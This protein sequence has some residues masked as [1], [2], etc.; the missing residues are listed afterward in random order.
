M[1]KREIMVGTCHIGIAIIFSESVSCFVSAEKSFWALSLESFMCMILA[2]A[3]WTQKANNGPPLL[4]VRGPSDRS[5]GF[6]RGKHASS[7]FAVLFRA[8]LLQMTL[9]NFLKTLKTVKKSYPSG[10]SSKPYQPLPDFISQ[11]LTTS[12]PLDASTISDLN[13]TTFHDILTNPDLK[14]SKCFRF[15]NLVIKNQS[16]VSFKPDLQAHLTLTC[17]LLKARLFSDAEAML[18]SVSVD[19]SLRYPFLVIASAVENCCFESK[20]ITKFYNLMLKVY[21]DNGKFGEVLKTFDYMKN[22]GIKI[23]ERTCTVHL[24]ALKGA[25]ELGLAL[26][27][28]YLM[29]ETGIEISVY[30]LTAVV[31]G[32]CRNGDVKKGR[33]IVEEMAD[34]GIKANVIT[35]N[36]MIDACAKRWD[37]E[38]LDLVLG[39]MEK[40]GV[41]FNVETFKF[42]IDGY[43]SYGKINEAGRLI[44]E[45]H[46]KGLKVDT[47]LYNLMINGYCKLGS[48]E[49]V[50]LLFDRMSNRGVKPNADT[51][52][53]LINGYS[54]VGEMEMAMKYVNEMQKK[55]F[56]LDKVMYDMLIDRFCQNGMV[57]EAFELRIEME[58][59]G[60]HSDMYLCNQMGKLLC[61]IYQTEKAKMLL[62]I[63]IKRGV[64]PKAV[65]FTSAIS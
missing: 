14:A 60:F 4:R 12:K 24:I 62:N 32:L 53:P 29:V 41:E 5:S 19:E 43:T 36:I 61:E 31:D 23:D 34:R 38:E 50:L 64:C 3:E 48:I 42:L 22:N 35:Y 47:Y 25:D 51:Y 27:F 44:G 1:W 46:D 40:A 39:L 65:S 11:F 45:M 15:F 10:L 8:P 57:D 63:M 54:K 30:S 17:R 56:E 26:H 7:K 59:K 20:V 49:N 13:P 55:G 2:L 18:K 21:S 9:Q 16:L 6:S 37:F 28:F 58:R 52:W 33:E